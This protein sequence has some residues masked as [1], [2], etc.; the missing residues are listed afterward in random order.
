[1]NV[2]DALQIGTGAGLRHGDRAHHFTGRELRQPSFL[3]ILG[4]VMQNVRSDDPRMERCAECIETGQRKFAIDHRFMRKG[5]A[6][7]AIFLRHRRAQKAGFTGLVPDVAVVDVRLVP[8]VDMRNEFIGN[9]TP[10]LLFKQ[11]KVFAHP[12]RAREIDCVH[13]DSIRRT[14]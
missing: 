13:D 7:A 2:L 1:M 5:A 8:A 4:A 10:R 11:D 3:L 9:E 6:G 14:R 12:G